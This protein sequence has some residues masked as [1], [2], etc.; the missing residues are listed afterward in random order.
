MVEGD[1]QARLSSAYKFT[2]LI[3]VS[4]DEAAV[5]AALLLH[6]AEEDLGSECNRSWRLLL[7]RSGKKDCQSDKEVTELRR[8]LGFST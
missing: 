4:E 7:L 8:D 3:S 1:I 5:Q 2:R 6:R